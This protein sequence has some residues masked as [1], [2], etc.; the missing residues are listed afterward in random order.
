MIEDPRSSLFLIPYGP[1]LGERSDIAP[2]AKGD[3]IGN[4][5]FAAVS[6]LEMIEVNRHSYDLD[7]SFCEGD[8]AP[9]G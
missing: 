1:E 8:E 2:I 5:A 3:P 4:G 6:Q 9:I 7:C